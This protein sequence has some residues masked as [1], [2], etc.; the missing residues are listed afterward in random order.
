MVVAVAIVDRETANRAA[1]SMRGLWYI[2]RAE[3]DW[4]CTFN[5]VQNFP[6]P[7]GFARMQPCEVLRDICTGIVAAIYNAEGHAKRTQYL[8]NIEAGRLTKQCRSV[9][10]LIAGLLIARRAYLAYRSFVWE[11]RLLLSKRSVSL[12]SNA[13][14]HYKTKWRDN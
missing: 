5:K 14:C 12:P 9:A 13:S 10:A 6:D 1:S 8:L 2:T 4:T 11:I 7:A 3:C